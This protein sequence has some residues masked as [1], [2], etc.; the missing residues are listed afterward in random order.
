M[1]C[2]AEN[3]TDALSDSGTYDIDDHDSVTVVEARRQIDKVFGVLS[4]V[5][6]V[7]SVTSNATAESRVTV[8]AVSTSNHAIS[9]EQEP[10]FTR[11][12]FRCAERISGTKAKTR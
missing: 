4:N 6:S 7:T 9:G 5:S 1:L 8:A 11:L 10:S 3:E 2:R 12:H